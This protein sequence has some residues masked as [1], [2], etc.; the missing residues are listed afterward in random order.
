M[1]VRPILGCWAPRAP[2][3]VRVR[4]QRGRINSVQL[5]RFGRNEVEKEKSRKG[6]ELIREI[7][8]L[9]E[10]IIK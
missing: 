3:D 5:T 8:D 6:L 10:V 4:Y 7:R 1:R 9:A 2:N